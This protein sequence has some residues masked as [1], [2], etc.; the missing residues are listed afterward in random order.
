[1]PTIPQSG[2]T[3]PN[4]GARALLLGLEDLLGKHGLEA[5]L[6]VASLTQWIEL[7]PSDTLER[8]VDFHQLTAL[9]T[10]LNEL[11]GLRSGSGLARLANR[12]TF[13]NTWGGYSA[14][15]AF[16]DEQFL[17]LPPRRRLDV[18]GVALVRVFNQISDLGIHL[19]PSEGDLAFEFE[20]CPYCMGIES[21]RPV[22]GA[23]AGW[24]EGFLQLIQAD[25][26]FNVSETACAA[27]NGPRCI[28]RVTI[29]G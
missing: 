16:R 4:R 21:D 20:N 24:I 7:R 10:A 15:A 29:E 28:F 23:T 17:S 1:M 3:Y 14:L 12:T 6:K 5:L 18:G 2:L 26:Q 27:V 13:E 8:E 19:Q 9:S 11:Y 25:A 22:C